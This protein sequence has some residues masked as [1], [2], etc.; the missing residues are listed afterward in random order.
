MS[1][2]WLRGCS[3]VTLDRNN[4]RADRYSFR[5]V[6]LPSLSLLFFFWQHDIAI[7]KGDDEMA[8]TTTSL[9]ENFIMRVIALWR[10]AKR[11]KTIGSPGVT[12]FSDKRYSSPPTLFSLYCSTKRA[13]EAVVVVANDEKGRE[14]RPPQKENSSS[15]SLSRSFFFQV[16]RWFTLGCDYDSARH[17]VENFVLPNPGRRKPVDLNL[18]FLFGIVGIPF[19]WWMTTAKEEGT[20]WPSFILRFLF[21]VDDEKPI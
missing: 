1:V 21:P 8:S 11:N 12:T 2:T 10:A 14:K 5:K 20:R 7:D 18:R 19:K 15:L 16:Q 13:A 6:A 9:D 4:Q 3:F 17:Y